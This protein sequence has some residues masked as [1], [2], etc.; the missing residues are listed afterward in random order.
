MF[1]CKTGIQEAEEMVD[2]AI[3]THDVVV[4]GG[5]DLDKSR[6]TFTRYIGERGCK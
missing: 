3:T 4:N 1:P 6:K 5:F 2:G